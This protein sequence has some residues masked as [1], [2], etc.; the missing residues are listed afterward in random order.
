MSDSE[1]ALLPRD[2]RPLKYLITL[3]PD[4]ERSTFSGQETVELEVAQP[5]SELV[6][7]AADLE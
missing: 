3:A 7:H 6:F 2:V 4:L 1:A 5:C